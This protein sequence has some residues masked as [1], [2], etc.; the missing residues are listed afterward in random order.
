MA[1]RVTINESSD[2]SLDNL[3]YGV[4]SVAGSGPKIGVAIGDFVLDLDVLAKQ[5]VF[6]D[7]NFDLATLGQPNLN[8]YAALG[9]TVHS[10]FRQRLQD[11]LKKDTQYGDVLR[12]NQQLRDKALVP[13]QSVQMHL[14]MVIGDY[15]DFFVGLHHAKT[16]SD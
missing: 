16:V 12:D 8:A 2:F 7:L 6:N 10:R 1:S 11:L 9:R 5:G 3:P 4:F 15:T 13:L 14:P